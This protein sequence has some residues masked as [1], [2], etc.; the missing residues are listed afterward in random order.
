[1]VLPVEFTD[2]GRCLVVILTE[3][4]LL[5]VGIVPVSDSVIPLVERFK[6]LNVQVPI[7]AQKPAYR[8]IWNISN[9]VPAETSIT[10]LPS[11]IN[12]SGGA[13]SGPTCACHTGVPVFAFHAA[14]FWP[15]FVN[16]R[17]PA[18]ESSPTFPLLSW[19][20]HTTL[21]VL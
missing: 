21:P 2:N 12:V 4:F 3:L 16:S 5:P 13:E 1:M 14:K 9:P 20:R 8:F 17:P 19:C 15:S 6:R 10:C 11:S 18:V 7:V